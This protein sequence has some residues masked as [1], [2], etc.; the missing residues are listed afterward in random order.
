M[1]NCLLRKS[2][3]NHR[4]II[5]KLL[6]YVAS[7]HQQNPF[8]RLKSH[9]KLLYPRITFLGKAEFEW[10]GG[11]CLLGTFLIFPVLVDQGCFYNGWYWKRN[12]IIWHFIFFYQMN[13]INFYV[14]S[15]YFVWKCLLDPVGYFR[16][17]VLPQPP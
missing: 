3:V 8:F 2:L 12:Y 5:G 16:I 4:I 7:R 9:S 1:F 13:I 11:Q 10:V 15:F 14:N 17:I 6:K